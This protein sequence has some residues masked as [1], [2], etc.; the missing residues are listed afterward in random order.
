[1]ELMEFLLPVQPLEIHGSLMSTRPHG[2]KGKMQYSITPNY[3]LTTDQI[4]IFAQ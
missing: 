3:F 4:W 1:M 2:K